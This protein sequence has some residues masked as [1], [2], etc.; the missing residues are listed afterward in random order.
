MDPAFSFAAEFVASVVGVVADSFELLDASPLG[1]PD[2]AA[3]AASRSGAEGV[4]VAPLVDFSVA[5][6]SSIA[7][8]AD[9]IIAESSG[10]RV[11]AGGWNTTTMPAMRS[12]VTMVQMIFMRNSKL[13]QRESSA[14]EQKL[15]ERSTSETV[16]TREVSRSVGD[17]APRSCDTPE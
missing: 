6:A 8:S 3:S 15:G 10:R 16:G 17:F 1:A 9:S 13:D 14:G 5:V 4:V 7:R 12:S 2:F 11:G